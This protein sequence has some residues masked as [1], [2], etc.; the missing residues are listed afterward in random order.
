MYFQSAPFS[1]RS[2]PRVPEFADSGLVCVMDARCALCARG[3]TWIARNDH[4][5]AFTIIPL[6]SDLGGA[7]MHHYGMDPADPTSWLFLDEGRAYASLDALIRVGLCLGRIWKALIL[8]RII[9]KPL[10]DILYRAVARNR[11]RLFGAG[12]LCAL[13]D[14]EVQKRL[15]T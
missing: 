14:P 6:Q 7:L 4:A 13:P 10:R 11:Y 1:H 5:G 3:A 2:D 8:L 12:D 15:L 9:P